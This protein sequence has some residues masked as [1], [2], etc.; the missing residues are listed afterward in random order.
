MRT[1]TLWREDMPKILVAMEQLVQAPL[2]I[3]DTSSISEQ[4][5]AKSRRLQ[6]TTGRLDLV[7]VDYLQLMSPGARRYENRTQEVSAVSRG[8]KSLAKELQCPVIALSQLSRATETRG[9]DHRPQL[10]DLGNQ[11]PSSKTQTW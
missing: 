8:L 10:A 3:D 6:Q 5:R 1:G 9:G 7:I 2:Y 11:G 4:M